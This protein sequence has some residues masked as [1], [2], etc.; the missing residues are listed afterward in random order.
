[1]IQSF[2][3]IGVCVSDLDRS[4]RFYTEVLGFTELFS[5]DFNDELASTMETDDGF[6]SR[7]LIRDDIRVE[8]LH[9][10]DRTPDG[11]GQRRPMTALGLT[12]LCFRVESAEDLFEAAAA[13]GGAAHPA[14][15]SSLDGGVEVVY[16]TDPDGIRIECMAG[17]PD[18]A[19]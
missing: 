4:T 18:L 11:D 17:V 10:R 8:L 19:G 3:H 12:H 7:M 13:F 9:W 14:T 16:L 1:V 6:T 2:S 5:F 15:K